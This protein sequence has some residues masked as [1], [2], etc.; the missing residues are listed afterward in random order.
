MKKEA[1]IL[2]VFSRIET[3]RAIPMSFAADFG[4]TVHPLCRHEVMAVGKQCRYTKISK[5]QYCL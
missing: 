3:V 2:F 1:G 5:L 4:K